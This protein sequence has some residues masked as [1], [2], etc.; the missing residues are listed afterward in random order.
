MPKLSVVVPAY[1]DELSIPTNFLALKTELDRHAHLFSYEIILV[2][3]GSPDNTILALEELHTRFPSVAGVVNLTRNFGQVAAIYAGLARATGDCA[4]VISSDLQDPPELIAEMFK[5]W[6]NGAKTVIGVRESREDSS[7]SKSTSRLFYRLMQRY[8]L[9]A[10]PTS[11]FDFFLLDRAVLERL[12]NST[13]QNGFLQG[14]ILSASSKVV[15]IPYRRRARKLGKSGWTPLRKLKYFVDGFVAY[16]FVPIRLITLLGLLVFVLAVLLSV[17]LI[18]QRLFFGTE[19]PGWS[20]VMIALLILHGL[21][22]LAIGVVGEYVWRAL[23]QVR[24]RPLYSVDYYKP[25]V[26]GAAE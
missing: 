7:F 24:P 13:E 25:P 9:P 22:L 4:A 21:E 20:S 15:Q 18:L 5:L 6:L 8:A 19:A 1:Q 10:I 17:A 26:N 12:L 3:D 23:D 14:H 2:N 16:S 11:G